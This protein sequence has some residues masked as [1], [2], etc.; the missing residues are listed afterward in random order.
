MKAFVAPEGVVPQAIV[1]LTQLDKVDASP[2]HEL[3]ASY[4][5]H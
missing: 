4:V 3:L 5:A 1:H 2:G